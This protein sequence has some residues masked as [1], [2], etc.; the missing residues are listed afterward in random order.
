MSGGVDSSV[1]AASAQVRAGIRCRRHDDAAVVRRGAGRR[2]AQPLL[3]A[4][5][6]AQRPASRRWAR[7]PLLRARHAKMSSGKS[8]S[9]S[10]SSMGIATGYHAQ[11]LPGVQPAYPLRVAAAI[12][13]SPW[14]PIIWRPVTTRGLRGS[15]ESGW[16]LRQGH[17]RGTKTRATSLSVH[18]AGAIGEE[19]SFPV[20]ERPK[21][22]VR[23]H[24]PAELG[25]DFANRKDSQDLCFLG[26]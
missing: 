5:P 12:M 13:P 17:R 24:G 14:M 6:D 1:A 26:E 3:H 22:D 10:I 2:R 4:R 8:P 21:S 9:S 15:A 23:R 18:G 16:R 19:R 25:L 7:H 20:G 11:P